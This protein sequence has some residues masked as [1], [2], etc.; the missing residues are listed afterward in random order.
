MESK[1]KRPVFDPLKEFE[2][3]SNI[4]VDKEGVYV[5]LD[6]SKHKCWIAGKDGKIVMEVKEAEF[7]IL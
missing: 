3:R 5:S 4:T 7:K 2:G 6:M 1:G